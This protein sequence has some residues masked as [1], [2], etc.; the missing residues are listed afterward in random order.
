[1][2]VQAPPNLS[3]DYG[4]LLLSG[5]NDWGG[6][7]PL[8]PDFVNPEAP[9]PEIGGLERL[10]LDAGY[11]L[12]ERLTIY[13]EYLARDE[14]LHP[15]MRGRVRAMADADGL[16]RDEAP[17][18]L[19]AVAAVSVTFCRVGEAGAGPSPG[20]RGG[21]P[22]RRGRGRRARGGL[23]PVE[24]ADAVL[25]GARLGR[26]PPDRHGAPRPR[27]GR[28]A[29]HRAPRRAAG[30]RARRP[31][32]HRRRVP[33]HRSRAARGGDR[34]RLAARGRPRASRWRSARSTEALDAIAAGAVDLVVGDWD[35]DAVAALRDAIAPR[36]LVERTALPPG[37]EIDD[38]RGGA[39]AP[40]LHRLARPGGRLGRGAAALPPGRR[41]ATRRPRSRR[42]ACRPS[43]RTRPGARPVPSRASGGSTRTSRGSSSARWTARRRGWPRSSGSSVPAGR[44]SRRSPGSP[45]PCASGAA[46]RPSPTSSTATSTT[47]TSATS[48]AASAASRAGPRASTCAATPTS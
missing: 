43:G 47:P 39:G 5:I 28:M 22:R 25:A 20:A 18:P 40:P 4:P 16:A 26:R 33:A 27:G 14:F 23:L 46:A 19:A 24:T 30:R 10:C 17:R 37:V 38:A 31:R 42:G 1:M 9:W 11:A 48:A 12:R 36:A 2:S 3:A 21:R 6:V 13:P 32:P 34:A 15:D 44:R 7:S 29:D 8:T 41:G 35:A 45:T